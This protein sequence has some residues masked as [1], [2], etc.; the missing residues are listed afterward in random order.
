MSESSLIVRL[1]R[2]DQ[3]ALEQIYSD[4]R[5][6]FI[7]FITNTHNCSEEQ[8]IDIYQY[9]ILSFYENVVDGSFE[10]MNIA[11][12]KTYLYSIGKN[13]LLGDLRKN[14]RITFQGE[15]KEG[16]LILEDDEFEIE[17]IEK[18]DKVREVINAMGDPCKRILELYY[19]NKLPN[20]EIAEIMGYNTAK[21]VKN[22]KYK[23][24]QRIKKLIE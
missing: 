8:A 2:G 23:C 11:G 20:E 18:Y 15:F 17:K 1:K 16:D 14:T 10:E 22:L 6:S 24:I 9:A 12:I 19:F 3:Q 4:Y 21:T 7:V 5:Q 13:K